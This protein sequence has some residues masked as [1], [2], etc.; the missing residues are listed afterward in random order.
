MAEWRKQESRSQPGRFYYFNCRT[1]E[2][3]WRLPQAL[4]P[5]DEPQRSARE[6]VDRALELAQQQVEGSDAAGSSAKPPGALPVKQ[7]KSTVATPAGSSLSAKLSTATVTLNGKPSVKPSNS[8]TK[9]RPPSLQLAGNSNSNSNK[10]MDTSWR[11]VL[12]QQ[13]TPT[14]ETPMQV[15]TSRTPAVVE[16][17]RWGVEEEVA[18]DV[19]ISE[20]E[21]QVLISAVQSARST[22]TLA[23]PTQ[24]FGIPQESPVDYSGT[25]F[26]VLDTNVLL[27]HLSFLMELKDFAIKGVGRPVLVVPWVVMQELD[28]LKEGEGPAERARRAI[29]ALHSCFSGSHPRVRGQ[30]M[31]EVQTEVKNLAITNND[32]RILHCCLV[33]QEKVKA[34]RGI[35]VLF[36]NDLQL[37]SKAMINDL[38]ALN[39]KTLL[40]ELRSLCKH[41]TRATTY[42]DTQ[43]YAARV[44]QHLRLEQQRAVADD[45]L[46]EA[47]SVVREGLAAAIQREMV[48]AY[49]DLWVKVVAV[50]P[51][52]TLKDLTHLLDKH[53]VAVFRLVLPYSMKEV[54]AALQK[55]MR[56]RNSMLPTFQDVQHFLHNGLDILR[57][58]S[59][60]SDC[61]GALSYCMASLSA[62]SQRLEEAK[63]GR[64]L[65]PP[66]QL[67]L[68][69]PAVPAPPTPTNPTPSP[70]EHMKQS[71][72]RLAASPPSGSGEQLQWVLTLVLQTLNY[73]HSQL[74]ETLQMTHPPPDTAEASRFLTQLSQLLTGI[75]TA[76]DSLLGQGLSIPR[77]QELLTALDTFL[78]HVL[79]VPSP[80]TLDKFYLVSNESSHLL[81]SALQEYSTLLGQFKEV[82]VRFNL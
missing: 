44:E 9:P 57:G 29:T 55:H 14:A 80:L 46:C 22:I 38:K 40:H 70:L 12:Q 47:E 49:D 7:G 52:W 24:S 34:C 20:E 56:L 74:L 3:S 58:F 64:L 72:Q 76:M 8:Q 63:A 28:W 10:P 50:K 15:D 1:G 35:V 5:P 59:S 26:I 2:S 31:A 23:T 71:L 45:L 30:T 33:Y 66:S 18:M 27:S 77:M 43:E 25:L 81:Q 13:Q 4:K 78:Q 53:W 17:E 82:A 21:Q 48:E 68:V 69:A 11:N 62:L 51:P 37:C 60:N 32:D 6:A 73:C 79:N 19:D 54:T 42:T 39:R 65:P 16:S 61:G 36:S 67:Q 41:S 75:T